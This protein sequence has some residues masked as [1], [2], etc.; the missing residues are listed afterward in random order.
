M[1]DL[2]EAAYEAAVI[3]E[4]WHRVLAQL[5]GTVGNTS[6]AL[7]TFGDGQ[8]ARYVAVGGYEGAYAEYMA[9]GLSLPNIRLPRALDR[10]PMGFGHDLELCT[11]EELSSD[12][13]YARFLRPHGVSWTAGT[14]VPVPT[15]DLLVIET[16]RPLNGA[17]HTRADTERLDPFRPHL[18]RAALLA[19]RLGLR[20]ARAA[21]EA[22]ETVGLPAA[23]LEHDRSVVAA[24]AS[25]LALEPRVRVGAFDRLYLQAG[26]ADALLAAALVRP[27]ARTPRSIPLPAT[28]GSQALVAHLI[29]VIRAAADIFTRGEAILVFTVVTAPA[30]PLTEVLTGLFDLTPAEARVARGISIGLSLA[31]IAM[32]NSVSHETVRTQ[33][34]S[35]IDK[36]GT[37]RQV[38]LA[39]LLSGLRPPHASTTQRDE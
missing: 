39:I 27:H 34:K 5:A 31:Q 21:A 30:A 22:L 7:V 19:H 10:H 23:V 13:L 25:L 16:G 12:P 37:R 18:A 20:A 1:D 6:A 35:V 38:D 11:N 29:P 3:P 26:P 15:G 24:N 28:E 4:Y 32:T 36:T 14:V 17:P 2:A 8:P 33:L 9:S